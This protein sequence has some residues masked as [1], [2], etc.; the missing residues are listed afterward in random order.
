MKIG[1]IA[2]MEEELE[3]LIN[4]LSDLSEEDYHGYRFYQ[5]SYQE[6]DLVI[7][8]AGIG[9]VNASLGLALMQDHYQLD[10]L[11]NTGTAGALDE[12]LEVGDFVIAHSL[13]YHDVDVTGFG[14]AYGQMAGMPE[15]YQTSADLN[16]VLQE[17]CRACDFEPVL[18][19]VVSGD[20]FIASQGQK[21]RISRRFPKARACEMESTALAQA[22]YQMNLPF[23]A[24][25]VISDK[26]DGTA[27][28][29]FEA[30]VRAVSGFSAQVV[31]KAVELL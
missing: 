10:C 26:A 18:G 1:I 24:L 30:F 2:A 15:R 6:H 4:S 22:A 11:I 14:Y 20:Q 19:L 12:G 7:S 29:S 23:A 16:R 17:A 3:A 27:A 28:M 9:K 31:L 13:A 8:Q 25:R 5:G 21:S